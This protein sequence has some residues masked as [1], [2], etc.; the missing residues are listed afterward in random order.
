MR[1]KKLKL[2]LYLVI[3]SSSFEFQNDIFV[4]I[5]LMWNTIGCKFHSV[6]W[7]R[8]TS[9]NFF[10]KF[11]LMCVHNFTNWF[12]NET[13]ILLVSL[14]DQTFSRWLFLLRKNN[15]VNVNSRILGLKVIALFE[16]LLGWNNARPREYTS[17]FCLNI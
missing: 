9:F 13:V 6:L 7:A 4:Y 1:K 5:H 2:M 16:R 15:K 14:L 17:F 3:Y 8:F 12:T 11:L 10:I